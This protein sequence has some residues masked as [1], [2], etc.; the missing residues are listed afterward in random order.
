MTKQKYVH[1][2]IIKSSNY[3]YVK[4]CMLLCNV[5][6][7]KWQIKKDKKKYKLKKHQIKKKGKCIN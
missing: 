6:L 1:I 4:I 2:E 3:T 7:K 5:K